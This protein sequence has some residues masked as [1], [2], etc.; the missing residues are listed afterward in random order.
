MARTQLRFGEDLVGDQHF[1]VLFVE[2]MRN[3]IRR[4]AQVQQSALF[5]RFLDPRI[6]IAVAVEEDPLVVF[7]RL[8]DHV[9]QRSLKILRRLQPV[10]IDAQRFRH[11]GVEHDVR[12]GDG[13]CRA[14]HAKLEFVARKRK[15][16]GAVAVGSVF[17]EFRQCVDAEAHDLLFGALIR[18]VLFDRFENGGQLVAEKDRY[19]RR[20]SFVR[21]EPV[22]VACRGH[23]DAQKILIVVHRLDHGAEEQQKLRVV[24]RRVAGR[25]QV[26]ARVGGNGPVVVLAAAVDAGKRLFMQQADEIVFQRNLLHNFHRELVV[27][28]GDVRC[29]IDRREFVLRRRNLVVLG[30][31]KDAKLP[32]FFVEVVHERLHARLD[33]A[34]IVV[35]ELLPLGRRRAEQCTSGENQVLALLIQLTVN[36]KVFLLGADTGTHA[37]DVGVPE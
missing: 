3:C 5:G 10:G 19:H 23:G 4:C 8:A 25:Q 9:M 29:R 35:V 37:L 30:F 34:E 12:A 20:R 21:A 17:F 14:E 33:H 1:D 31:G 24:I 26:D 16:R 36:K 13:V 11:G 18:L 27:V 15:R 7:D 2:Q 22:I 32:E 6:I 28:G